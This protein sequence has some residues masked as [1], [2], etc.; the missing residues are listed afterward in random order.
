MPFDTIEDI[1]RHAKSLC[2]CEAPTPLVSQWVSRRIAEV[3]GHK[4]LRSL[5]KFRE[6]WVP[7]GYR[8]G[9][10]TFTR[11]SVYVTGTGT[12]WTPAMAGR[13]IRGNTVY[14]RIAEVTSPTSLVLEDANPFAENSITNTAYVL[15]QR[16]QKLPKD[17]QTISAKSVIHPRVVRPLIMISLDEANLLYPARHFAAGGLPA[18]FWEIDVSDDGHRQLELFPY[19]DQSEI[20]Y[21][22]CWT[23]PPDYIQTDPVP[24]FIHPYVIIEGV[25]VDLYGYKASEQ[26]DYQMA[27][28]WI[29]KQ[30]RQRTLWEAKISEALMQ[31][32]GLTDGQFIV[33][34]LQ[35]RR[36]YGER[37]IITAYD[38]VWVG[39]VV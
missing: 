32:K 28:L 11:D 2:K 39:N 7:G 33:E 9:T 31:E 12:A 8:T 30:D 14:Y 21:Y 1:A 27:A 3:A 26:T 23:K 17:V 35:Q 4:R 5:R 38:Q 36:A 22:L 20:I 24:P 18:H 13:Y 10:A 19:L 37:D 34:Q 6:L 15:V 25:L 29:N 16:F